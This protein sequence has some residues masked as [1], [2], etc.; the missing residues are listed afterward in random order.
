M[1]LRPGPAVRPFERGGIKFAIMKLLKDKPRHGYDIIRAMGEHSKGLYS[2]SA[3]A[4]YPVL[5]ALED[6]DLVA[7]ATKGGKRVY[8]VTPTGLAF[9]EENKEEAQRHEDRWMEQLA[10][11]GPGEPWRAVSDM[12]RTFEEVMNAVYA[13]ANDPAKR[14]EIREVMEEAAKKVAEIAKR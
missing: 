7:S 4:I 11:G 14:R 8:S 10:A 13:T 9:L 3:G 5:Q 2:P 12:N 1:G 6:Q